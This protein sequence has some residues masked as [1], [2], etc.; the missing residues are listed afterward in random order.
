MESAAL[1]AQVYLGLLEGMARQKTQE[2]RVDGGGM[3]SDLWCQIFADI[4][5]KPILVAEN[6]DGAGL[7]AAILGY[8]GL[9]K[10][11]TYDDAIKNM[12]RFV[13]T[14]QPIKENSKIYKKL[15]RIFMPAVLE[16]LNKKRIT[17]KL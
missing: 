15:I 7:G 16:I 17:G 14:K 11:S 3:N 6:K 5:K 8:Y 10:Y 2:L 1:S 12:V 9:K 4:I 13:D